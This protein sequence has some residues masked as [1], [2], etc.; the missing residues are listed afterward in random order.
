MFG[1]VG[2]YRERRIFAAIP[3]T[4]AANTPFSLLI[5]LPGA[6]GPRLGKGGGPGAGWVTFA[7]ESEADLAEALRL[8]GRA[9]E[10]ARVVSRAPTS[11]IPRRR[12]DR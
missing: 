8:L 9:Y 2:Y 12:T 3:R 7:M 11:S 6:K 5:K 1:M 10:Q 4:R